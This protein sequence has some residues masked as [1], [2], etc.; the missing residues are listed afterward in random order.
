[1]NCPYCGNKMEPGVLQSSQEISWLPGLKR[2]FFGRAEFHRGAVELSRPSF[3]RSSAVAAR[4]CRVC[5]KIV[6]DYGDEWSDLN[7]PKD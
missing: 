2:R 1:M 4:L 3:L 6:M 5:R 7:R